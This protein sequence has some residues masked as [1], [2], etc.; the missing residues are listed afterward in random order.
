[1]R[2]AGPSPLNV[3]N[4]AYNTK[5]AWVFS[6]LEGGGPSVVIR[7]ASFPVA[8]GFHRAQEFI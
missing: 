6:P 4:R 8:H 7:L 3:Y 5:M 2:I 1:M